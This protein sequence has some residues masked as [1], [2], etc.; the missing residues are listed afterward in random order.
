[1]LLLLLLHSE[2]VKNKTLN[3]CP[4][5]LLF[6]GHYTGQPAVAGTRTGDFA[7]E[8]FYCLH[9]PAAARLLMASGEI[10]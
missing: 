6:C 7:G 1:M 3:F 4:Y 9:A 10:R 5:L 8:K 2:S